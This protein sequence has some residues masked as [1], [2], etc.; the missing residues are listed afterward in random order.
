M[1]LELSHIQKDVIEKRLPGISHLAWVFAGVDVTKDPIPVIPTVH[2]NMGGIPA[3]Y[4]AQVS[5]EG[6]L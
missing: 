5:I 6:T 4:R 2:Y 1:H 3:N